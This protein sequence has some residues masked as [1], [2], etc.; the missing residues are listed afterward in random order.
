MPTKPKR[1]CNHPGCPNLTSERYCDKHK[2]L[3][4]WVKPID[5]PRM[6]GRK[7]Q[8]ERNRLFDSDPLCVECLKVGRTTPATQRDHIIPLAE[9]GLDTQENTQG[10]CQDCHDKKSQEESK[11]GLKRMNY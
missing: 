1:P 9:G 4:V 3:H 8:R 10:L 11:R 2:P 6:R 7:L 5:I